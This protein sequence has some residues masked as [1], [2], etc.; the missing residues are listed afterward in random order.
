[1]GTAALDEDWQTAAAQYA[2]VG[3]RYRSAATPVMPQRPPSAKLMELMSRQRVGVRVSITKI[4][5]QGI[6]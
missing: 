3:Q 5:S 2:S 6:E 1:M 4:I